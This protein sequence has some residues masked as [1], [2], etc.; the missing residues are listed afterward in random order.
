[1]S[2][3]AASIP[4]PPPPANEPTAT[5]ED[6]DKNKVFGILSYLWIL[7]L[8]PLLAAKDSPFA[9]FHANEGLVLFLAGIV[10]WFGWLALMIPLAFLPFLLPIVGILGP[11]ISLC[12]LALMIIG[13]INAANGKMKHL[14]VIGGRFK[15]IK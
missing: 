1:M 11:L 7:W 6:I 2:N 10:V 4:P 5:A 9:K 14:P 15:L 3:D 8:V 13:I 12:F